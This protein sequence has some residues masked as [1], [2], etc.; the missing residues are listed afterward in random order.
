MT[1]WNTKIGNQMAD[2]K[3]TF[4]GGVSLPF[5]PST[6]YSSMVVARQQATTELGCL[7]GESKLATGGDG[8]TGD[9]GDGWFHNRLDWL[10]NCSV[11]GG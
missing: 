5:F 6:Q 2:W 1:N 11:Y 7:A 3:P 9:G 10:V 4:S 8:F